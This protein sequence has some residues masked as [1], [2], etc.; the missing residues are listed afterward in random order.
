MRASI[1]HLRQHAP[2]AGLFLDFD[3]TLSE[4]VEHPDEARPYE[5]VT[6]LLAEL[7]LR[8]RNVSI[9]SG[10]SADQLLAW[11]GPDVDIWGIHG[12]QRVRGG[13][14]ELSPIAAPFE[15]LM[16]R[17]LEEARATVAAT[18]LE[19]VLVEDKQVM[20]GLHYRAATDRGAAETTL[21]RI[22][23]DLARSHGLH[24]VGGRAALELRPPVEFSKAGVLVQVAAE[25]DLE[26]A[27]FAGDDLVDLPGFDALDRLEEAGVATLRVAVASDESPAELI[28]RADLTVRGPGGLVELLRRLL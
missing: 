12:A 20:V 16:Q 2:R 13:R 25:N 6:D 10:R 11:L 4:I 24:V 3:G 19:G 18:G 28:E 22:A 7:G 23:D 15:E 14:V 17:V 9:V 5:T 26:A 21:S 27:L 1:E 8:Y